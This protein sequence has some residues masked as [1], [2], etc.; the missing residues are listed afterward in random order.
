MSEVIPKQRPEF[1]NIHISQIRSYRLPLA[2]RLS[3]LHRVS[4]ILLFLA[5]PLV[6]LPLFERSL[7]SELGFLEFKEI[8][9]QWW[10]KIILLGLIW[11]YLH[12]FTAGIRFLL[13]DLHIGIQKEASRK[14]AVIV[15]GVSL[16][17]TALF[18]LKLFGVI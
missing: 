5:I 10:V 1:R 17:L 18:G 4:G 15:F 8:V 16:A 9:G 12:H 2:G 11:G 14:S 3:I 7:I 13:L 6:I